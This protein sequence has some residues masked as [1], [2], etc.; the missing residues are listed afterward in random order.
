[1]DNDAGLPAE[2]AL[3]FTTDI[4]SDGDKEQIIRQVLFNGEVVEALSKHNKLRAGIVDEEVL[5]RSGN[6][7]KLRPAKLENLTWDVK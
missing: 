6:E 7:V 2:H 5:A 3:V 1:M 4:V